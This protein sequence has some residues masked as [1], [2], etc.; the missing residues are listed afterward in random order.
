MLLVALV[1]G[2][3][4][5]AQPTAEIDLLLSQLSDHEKSW[6]AAARLQKSGDT[7]IHALIRH[8]RRD[9]FS[10]WFHGNHSPTMKVLEKLGEAAMPA[11]SASLTPSILRTDGPP[12]V[13]FVRSVVLVMAR[14]DPVAAAPDLVRVARTST[15]QALREQALRLV[16]QV[17]VPPLSRVARWAGCFPTLMPTA[18]DQCPQDVD[19]ARTTSVIRPLLPDIAG[20]LENA[21]TPLMRVT[22]AR[23]LAGWGTGD[24][25]LRGETALQHLSLRE[26]SVRSAAIRSIGELRMQG[27][28][29]HLLTLVA[30]ADEDSR[31]AIVETLFRIGDARYF[32]L[33]T[34]LMSS[35]NDDTRRWTIDFAGASHNPSFVPHLIARLQDRGW[36]GVT[37]TQKTGSRKPEVIRHTLAENARE[38][39]ERLTFQDFGVDSRAWRQWWTANAGGSW[40]SFLA[41][42]VQN[43]MAAMVSAEPYAINGW[44]A[45]VTEADHAAVLPLIAGY[46]NHPRLDTSMVGPNLWSSADEQPIVHVLLELADRQSDRARELL[47]DCLR[48]RDYS[49]RRACAFAIATFDRARALDWLGKQVA[50]AGHEEAA[51]AAVALLQLGDPQGIPRLLDELNAPD[52]GRRFNAFFA[53]KHYTQAIEKGPRFLEAYSALGRLYADLG[54]LEQSVQVLTEA[55]KVALK[56][57]EEEAQVHH[58]LGTVYQ[59]QKKYDDAV[60]EFR[61]ALDVVPGMRD[62]LFSLGWTYDLQGNKE[63]AKRYLQKFVD[64]AGAEAPAHYVKAARDKLSEMAEG[65]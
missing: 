48:A 61:A 64:V 47:Y 8:L 36:N 14:I 4:A 26:P 40:E 31:M 20:L 13:D 10:D 1:V 65:F 34:R 11:L 45:R 35:V 37:T 18:R 3:A 29:S 24:L 49:L 41:G 12:D 53:L 43:R 58:L 22:A 9:P 17:A 57:T 55:L 28:G 52:E 56:G 59:Q 44:I 32:E 63:E 16:P 23:L 51:S 6:S 62:A 60:R 46:L 15:N 39:L 27:L 7:A 5:T 33:A 50:A 2:R 30:T 54:Y 25:K 21:P 42:F 38:A 19:E